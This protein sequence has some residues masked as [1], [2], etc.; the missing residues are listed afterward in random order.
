M[1]SSR[2]EQIERLRIGVLGAARI[3]PNALVRPAAQLANVEVSAIAARDPTRAARFAARH[4]ISRVYPSYSALIDAADLDAIY[5]PLPNSHHALW[6]IRALDA[7]KHVLCE[8]PLAAN[9]DE[10]RAVA[11]AAERN[12][13][14]LCEAFHYAYHPLA[15]RVRQL[16]Q[17]GT[18]GEVKRISV[19][20][21]SPLLRPR[22]IR[23]RY[24]MAGGATMDLGCY[25]IHMLRFYS[26][27]EPSVHSA[28]AHCFSEQIDR[29]MEAEFTFENGASG[30]MLCSMFSRKLLRAIATIAGTRGEIR[31][32]NPLL[33]HFLFHR[34]IWL[35]AGKRH[36][37]QFRGPSTYAHQLSAFAE[38]VLDAKP[39][40]TD[41]WDAVRTMRLIDD[42][43][44]AA[45]LA[46]RGGLQR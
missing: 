6:S 11:E 31:V 45:G 9:A 42:V 27:M 26:G 39:C 30:H 33:P 17:S 19:A 22:N 18:I 24:A 10:A 32:Y 8:K 3:V 36:V 7:G 43:Y 15:Q 41:G 37:E 35:Q 40:P 20:L 1:D 28:R 12:Q 34:L 21:C 14:V 2:S 38:Q 46:V 13:R 25:A 29:T 5:I 4:A 44:V 16:V 23:Y